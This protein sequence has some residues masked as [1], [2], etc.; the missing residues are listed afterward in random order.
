MGERERR[1]GMFDLSD[2][3]VAAMERDGWEL[4]SPVRRCVSTGGGP[5][6]G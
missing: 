3:M 4:K 1:E 6:G 2:E 5:T